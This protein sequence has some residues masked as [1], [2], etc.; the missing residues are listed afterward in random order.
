MAKKKTVVVPLA[1]LQEDFYVRQLLNEN[2][3]IMLGCLLEDG[4]ELPPILITPDYQVID[5]RHRISAHDMIGRTEI[6]AQIIDDTNKVNL[7][8]MAYNANTGG[9][10]LPTKEDTEHTIR[11][12]LS[13]NVSEKKIKEILEIP[14]SL[15]RKWVDNVKSKLNRQKMMAALEAISENGLTVKQATD[16]YGVSLD[17]LKEALSGQR[18]KKEKEDA[19]SAMKNE[20]S[21]S[22]SSFNQKNAHMLGKLLKMVEDGDVT[23]Q[24]ANEI[25]AE[26]EKKQANS[27]RNVDKWKKRFR[28]AYE[29]EK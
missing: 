18:K 17:K 4:V 28:A 21:K 22:F 24:Q 19:V 1:D 6:R 12:L 7:I 2:H 5:G 23:P 13:Q 3:A 29:D 14:S 9:A 8:A 25:I 10:L 27:A 15:G 11:L 26:L 20:I 16:K